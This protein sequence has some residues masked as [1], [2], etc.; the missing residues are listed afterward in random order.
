VTPTDAPVA[1][2]RP[3]GRP[4]QISRDQIVAAALEI[5]MKDLT[6]AAVARRLGT[7]PQAFYRWVRD[8]DELFTLVAEALVER[9][10][11][12]PVDGRPWRD[13][14]GELARHVREALLT[15]P[16]LAVHS[17]TH[18][19]ASPGFL[20]INERTCEVLVGAGFTPLDAQRTYL[21]FGSVL[22]GWLAR[23]DTLR[24]ARERVPGEL[25]ETFAE[26][27]GR[28]PIVEQV[29][30]AAITDSSETRWEH[31]LKTLLDGLPGPPGERP[32]PARVRRS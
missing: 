31:M 18:Y 15:A 6:M 21:T 4:A 8:R 17:I 25:A 24:E 26:A 20:R 11:L 9:V 30:A 7:S 22:L 29:A 13:W 27:R 10:E 5:G 14:L 12:P 1:T 32:E 23:E 19:R 2:T 3:R 16:G 28:Y